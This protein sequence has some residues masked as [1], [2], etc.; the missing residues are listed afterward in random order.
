MTDAGVARGLARDLLQVRSA[1][2][3]SWVAA[4]ASAT[5]LLALTALAASGRMDLSAF[6]A[7]GAFA[8]VYGGP[9]R[10]AHRWRLQSELGA[11]LTAAVATGVV[12]GV[13]APRSWLAVAV[14]A[15]WAGLAS[16]WSLR[17]QWRPAGPLFLVFAASTSASI[18]TSPEGALLSCA[19]TA[20]T[21][22]VA[23]LLGLVE[24]RARGACEPSKPSPADLGKRIPGA[25]ATAVLVSGGVATAAG[26][27]HPSWAMV[28]AVVPFSAVPVRGQLVRGLH[29]LF[30]TAVGLA[31]AALLLALAPLPAI[32]LVLLVTGLQASVELLVARHYGMALVFITPLALLLNQAAA[33]VPAGEL[34]VSRIVET[35]LGVSVGLVVVLAVRPRGRSA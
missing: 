30:G 20:T 3:S 26:L 31:L 10:T 29:R 24:V 12:V 7:F 5:L 2:G 21:A 22:V 11:L 25:A 28:A 1:P 17:R 18:P 35:A 23:V 19:V 6:A 14:A 34:L 32:A 9:A 15:A 13:L 4:R 8:S 27:T 33:P 16:T